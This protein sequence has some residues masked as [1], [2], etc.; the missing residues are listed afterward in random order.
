MFW[1]VLSPY[2]Y[3]EVFIVVIVEKHLWLLRTN[4]APV[5]KALTA[6]LQPG[7]YHQDHHSVP[8]TITSW[9]C[10]WSS[11]FFSDTRIGHFTG[12]FFSPP[13]G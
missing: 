13:E 6:Y 8:L 10:L 3:S 11:L 2:I 5:P 4:V 12:F 9:P 1:L 7:M